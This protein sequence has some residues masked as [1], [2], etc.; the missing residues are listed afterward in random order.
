[1]FVPTLLGVL[2]PALS[3]SFAGTD[4]ALACVAQETSRLG[5]GDP[6]P[7]AAPALPQSASAIEVEALRKDA[8]SKLDA[9]QGADALLAV[10]KALELAPDDLELLDLAS[11]AAESA[12]DKDRALWYAGLALLRCEDKARAAEIEKRATAL[13]PLAGR[14]RATLSAYAAD[15]LALGQECANKKRFVNAVELFTRCRDTS[16]EAAAS[17]QLEKL[18]GN[19]GAVEAILASGFDVPIKVK[20]KRSPEAIAKEDKKHEEWEKAWQ[21]KGDQYTIITN[22][23]REM[24]DQMS[25]AMEQMNH[26]YRKVFHVKEHGGGETARVTISVFKSR[27]EFEEF[28]KV[29]DEGMMG[30]FS[31]SENR[32]ATYDTRDSGF[33]SSELWSTLFHES[34]HQFTHLVSADLIPGWLNE[35]TASYFEGAKLLPNGKVQTNLVPEMRL[36]ELKEVFEEGKPTLKDVVSYYE[37]GSYDGSYYSVGWSLV[38]FLLNYENE[39]SQRIYAPL[40][41]DYMAAYKSGGKHDVVGRFVEYFVTKAKDPAVKSFEDFEKRWKS[42]MLALQDVWFGGPEK[43]DILLARARAQMRDKQ[44]DVA[45]ETLRWA[46]QKR[47]NDPVLYAELGDAL[48]LD[49]DVDGALHSWARAIECARTLPAGD[50]KLA[51][52]DATPAALLDA[53]RAKIA[54]ADKRFGDTRSAADAR[55][56]TAVKEAAQAYA[57]AGLAR[58]AVQLLAR[59]RESFGGTSA[60]SALQK[61][62]AVKHALDIRRPLRLSVDET[63]SAWQADETLWRPDGGAI[64]GKSDNPRFCIYTGDLPERFRLEAHLD[65]SKASGKGFFGLAFGINDT[66][67]RY[68][69]LGP[70]VEVGK[71]GKQGW[72][73]DEVFGEPF[74]EAFKSGDLAIEF[75][76]GHAVFFLNGAQIGERDYPPDE[77]AG[78]VGL[79]VQG[80]EVR[81]SGIRVRS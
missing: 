53:C 12:Q 76:D 49:K 34:S 1:M 43:A 80:A 30:F 79:L 10:E 22:M 77:L 73:P 14:D 74:T 2:A 45:I 38:Y 32:V 8:Q 62:L 16:A 66:G 27:K 56:E 68:L 71:L 67:I 4:S 13:D 6:K 52:S 44:G 11:R 63:L 19:K 48:A 50:T 21:V 31:P 29:E 35:G 17:A 81:F 20:K 33:P 75:Q 57:D 55:V 69:G 9:G 25:L 70:G 3:C 61:M 60:L 5:G 78:T 42:W 7:A 51:G 47:P 46:L 24:A 41:G 36:R 39:K 23:G 15:L 72:K 28:E 37:D 65:V 40:Y 18:Y 59:A 54:K 58:T 26:F 64:I